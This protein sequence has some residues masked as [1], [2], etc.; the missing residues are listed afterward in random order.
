MKSL[1]FSLL[2]G[3]LDFSKNC[4]DGLTSAESESLSLD[5]P[6]VIADMISLSE[7]FSTFTHS[8]SFGS[9]FIVSSSKSSASKLPDNP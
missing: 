3:R 7:K 1:F 2:G 4:I 5:S 8:M 6:G 9:G